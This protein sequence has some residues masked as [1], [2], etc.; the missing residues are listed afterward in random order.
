[1]TRVAE[2]SKCIARVNMRLNILFELFII[3]SHV[4][5]KQVDQSILVDVKSDK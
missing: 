4:L 1:M 3:L 5:V 2:L